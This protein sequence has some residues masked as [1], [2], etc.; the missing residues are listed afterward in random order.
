MLNKLLY[1]EINLKM[2]LSCS[3]KL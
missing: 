2:Q 1:S 3:V